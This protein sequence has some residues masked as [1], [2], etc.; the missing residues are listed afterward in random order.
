MNKF[1]KVLFK[2]KKEKFIKN[3]R[4][5]IFT[6]QY[7]EDLSIDLV[8]YYDLKYEEFWIEKMK[9]DYEFVSKNIK[10]IFRI[11]NWFK[12]D[13]TDIDFTELHQLIYIVLMWWTKDEVKSLLA[14]EIKI[15]DDDLDILY[16]QLLDSVEET[17][18]DWMFY[19]VIENLAG[20]N[21]FF[22]K[23]MKIRR[24]RN[25]ITQKINW[26]N[27]KYIEKVVR[28]FKIDF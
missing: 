24:C 20:K 4:E 26:W 12:K 11:R 9:K 5:I 22:A 25:Y 15:S 23:Y 21:K 8:I 1:K 6:H 13:L 10:T 2:R 16:T 14:S 3:L 7:Y 27:L 17:K 19:G 28:K 18:E